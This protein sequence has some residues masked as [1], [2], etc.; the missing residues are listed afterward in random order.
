M[1]ECPGEKQS[2][3]WGKPAGDPHAQ[4]VPRPA[5]AWQWMWDMGWSPT[6]QLAAHLCTAAPSYLGTST[7]VAQV[8]AGQKKASHS[9]SLS[10]M[11]PPPRQCTFLGCLA[12][13]TMRNAITAGTAQSE[14]LTWSTWVMHWVYC[15]QQDGECLKSNT[16]KPHQPKQWAAIHSKICFSV[17]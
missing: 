8:R 13:L 9:F 4:L 7:E 17:L 5:V 16:G 2:A 10:E 3:E 11:G 12:E 1:H 6:L 15:M 14:C